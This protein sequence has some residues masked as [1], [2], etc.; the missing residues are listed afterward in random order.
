MFIEKR[1]YAVLFLCFMLLPIFLAAQ[2]ALMINPSPLTFPDIEVGSTGNSAVYISKA[3]PFNP[4][5]VGIQSISVTPD[6]FSYNFSPTLP[7][8]LAEGETV[9]IQLSCNPMTE[10][11]HTGYLIVTDH[12]SNITHVPLSATATAPAPL[13]PPL[14]VSPTI[15]DFGA[16]AVGDSLVKEFTVTLEAGAMFD[17]NSVQYFSTWGS[18]FYAYSYYAMPYPLGDGRSMTIR[19]VFRPVAEGEHNGQLLIEAGDLEVYEVDLS[20]TGTAAPATPSITISP[21]VLNLSLTE[22]NSHITQLLIANRG[23]LPFNYVIETDSLQGWIFVGESYDIEGKNITESLNPGDSTYVNVR[24]GTNGLAPGEFYHDQIRVR[25]TDTN[26]TS[27]GAC[28]VYL[29][30]RYLPVRAQFTVSST[31]PHLGDE[32]QFT[33]LSYTDPL[34]STAVISW[35]WDLD[36]DGTPDSNVQNPL[37]IYPEPGLYNVGLTVWNSTGSVNEEYKSDYILVTNNPPAVSTDIDSLSIA[38]DGFYQGWFWDFFT[39]PDGD[40]VTFSAYGEENLSVQ[41]LDDNVFRVVP[42]ADWFGVETLTMVATDQWGLTTTHTITVTVTPVNDPPESKLPDIFHFVKNSTLHLDFGSYLTDLDNP[43]TELSINMIQVA[44]FQPNIMVSYEPGHPGNLLAHYSAT[45]GWWGGPAY[46]RVSIN[47]HMGRAVTV[48]TLQITVLEHFTVQFGPELLSYNLA[49]QIIPFVDLTLGNPDWWEWD[50]DNDGIVDSQEQ[51]PEWFYPYSG[52]Y[53][54]KL[55]LGNTEAGETA[56][57]L[58]PDMFDMIGTAVPPDAPAPPVMDPPGSPY[59]I[60]G[61]LV[62]PDGGEITVLPDVT[63]NFLTEAPQNLDGQLNANGSIFQ[64]GGGMNNWGGLRFGPGS[65]GSLL[66]CRFLDSNSPLVVDGGNPS[67]ENLEFSPSDTL[68]LID[69]EGLVVEGGSPVITGSLI[70][71]YRTGV[72]LSGD[73]GRNTPTLTNIR[74]RNSSETNRT[75]GDEVTGI[76]IEGDCDAILSDVIVSDYDIGLL[77]DNDERSVST[78]TLTNIRVRNSSETQ[79]GL[80]VGIMISGS[81]AAQFE[82]VEIVG[83][84]SGLIYEGSGDASRTTPTLTN[85]RVR[86]SSETQRSFDTGIE[87]TDMAAINLNNVQ[88]DDYAMGISIKAEDS[89][90]VSTP[91]LT[92]IRVR[93][94]SETNRTESTGLT[95]SGNVIA[96]VTDLE[97]DNCTVGIRYEHAGDPARVVSTPTLTNIRVRNSSETNRNQRW[98]IILDYPGNLMLDDVELDDCTGALTVI[99]SERVVSTP[100]LT[101]IRVRNSSETQRFPNY[102]I[103]LNS[104]V[105]GELSGCTVESSL[106]GLVIV[107]G[108]LTEIGPNFFKNCGIGISASYPG[109]PR[110]LKLQSMKLEQDF[111]VLHQDW[112]FSA[113]EILGSPDLKLQQNT[114]L[115]YQ[116]LVQAV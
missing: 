80:P 20:G 82:D 77:L 64:P 81:V 54:V 5:P 112:S 26:G 111:V 102:G 73:G 96:R 52:L 63:V 39:E 84:S 91:T 40:N 67:L 108:N 46:Y 114:I 6:V 3:D 47:D 72:R 17:A 61:D 21:G 7:Y 1:L 58:V 116:S 87:I 103:M 104:G 71:N 56:F 113:F 33:D 59:N 25:A 60:Q 76:L 106:K 14:I 27:Y 13:T 88:V 45:P 86:S 30:V 107:P 115:G 85:I 34:S 24:V 11:P 89:R 41:R 110:K 78:P 18:N 109:L 74:V 94:S 101:N 35:S 23:S 2:S 53:S 55:T 57:L 29:E 28:D 93:N 90:A 49:G 44:P 50:F 62:F 15:W 65:G 4:A 68:A 75:E 10:G 97:T 16:V 22:G 70:R 66:N 12:L 69:G 31:T 32:V 51:N 92:N 100:T 19:A 9:E 36:G 105:Q 79:R 98:G 8:Y 83:A 38:E 48:D 42:L 95:L 37:Y 99:N 43:N